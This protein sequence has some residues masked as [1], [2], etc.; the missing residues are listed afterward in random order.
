MK[1]LTTLLAALMMTIVMVGCS[2]PYTITFTDGREITVPDKPRLHRRSDMYTYTDMY[3][4][5]V[6]VNKDEIATIE[7]APKGP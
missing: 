1:R 7:R 4:H 3:G 2:Q 6:E 5:K